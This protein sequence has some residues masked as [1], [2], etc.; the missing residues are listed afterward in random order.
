MC[1]DFAVAAHL[2]T[3]HALQKILHHG[4]GLSLVGVGIIFYGI[5]FDSNRSFY[6]HDHRFLEHDSINRHK[7][8]T[9]INVTPI[10]SNAHTLND[11][12]ISNVAAL[13]VV[14]ARLYI[15]NIEDTI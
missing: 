3:W 9:Q 11:S 5:L 2:Y 7:N 8:H 13:E 10:G 6:T 4:I 15:L 1:G 12:L 14:M